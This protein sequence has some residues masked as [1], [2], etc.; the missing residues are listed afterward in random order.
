MSLPF[1]PPPRCIRSVRYSALLALFLCASSHAQLV[2]TVDVHG[3]NDPAGDGQSDITQLCIDESGLPDTFEVEFSWDDDSF[4]GRNTGDACV[5]FD[6]DGDAAGNIDYALCASV[7]GIPGRLVAG[8]TFYSCSGQPDQCAG[9]DLIGGGGGTT[10]LG[11]VRDTD[12]FGSGNDFP[13]D[14]VVNCVVD[15]A[16][17]P[18]GWART[19]FCSFPSSQPN[20]DPKDCIGYFG[21]GFIEISKRAFP[22]DDDSAATSFSFSVS[23][24]GTEDGSAVEVDETIIVNGNSSNAISVPQGGPYTVSEASQAGWTTTEASCDGGNV[25]GSTV[26]GITVAASSTTQC[27]F[28]NLRAGSITILKA[29]SPADGTDFAFSGDLESFALD[30]DADPTLSDSISFDSPVPGTYT[31]TEALTPPFALDS[32]LCEGD[33]DGGSVV[34]L[35]QRQVAIDFDAAEGI[36]CTFTNFTGADI[37]LTKT[38]DTAEPYTVGQSIQYT[39]VVSN[40]GP[41][42]AT[43]VLVSDT[44]TNLTIDS[45]S[46]VPLGTC[47][48][49]PCT[50]AS[51]A[52]GASE[53]ITVTAT[54]DAVG[55]FDNT[56]T[57][58]ADEADPDPGNNTD[59][60]DNGG[61]A[62]AAADPVL[63]VAKTTGAT[64]DNG[65]G[66]FTT[67]VTITLENLGNVVL[68]DVQAIDDLTA[69]FPAPAN[70][71]ISALTSATLAVNGSYDGSIAP[72]LLDGTDA[73]A[74]G[75]Q[76]TVNFDLTF[77]PMGLPGPF[78]NSASGTAQSDDGEVTT[79]LS[80]NGTDPD[81]NGNGDPGDPGEDDATPIAF[82]EAP[83]LGVAKAASPITDNGDGTFTTTVTVT[84]ENLGN[85]VLREVQVSDD[86]SL[87]FPLP[88][89]FSVAN[90]TSPL[91]SANTFFDGVSDTDLLLGTDVLAVG[92]RTTVAFDVTFDP[93]VL[94][95]PF[96]NS[97]SGQAVG[98]GGSPT[99]DVS[100]E[101]N[102]PDASGDGDPGGP[103]EDDPT[104]ITFIENPVLGVAKA[105]SPTTDNGDGTFTTTI[106]LLVEN[107]GNVILQGVQISDDLS[108]AFPAPATVVV[109]SPT[110]PTLATDAAFDGLG[111]QDLLLGTDSLGVGQTATVSFQLTFDPAGLSGPFSNTA[112][113]NAQSPIGASTSD[114]SDDGSDSDPDADGDP[115]GPGEDD[116][117]AITFIE[118]PVLGVAK[119]ASPTTDNGD[120]SFTTTITLTLENLGNVSL[121]DLQASDDLGAVFPAPASVSIANLTSPLLNLNPAYDGVSDIDLL[122]GSDS[123]PV[124]STATVSFDITFNPN[125]LA[126][127]FSNMAL[128]SA[129]GPAGTP[130]SDRSDNG[131]ETDSSGDGDPGGPGEDDP[132]TITFVENPVVDIAK[133]S[134]PASDN[135]DGTFTTT[136]TLLVENLGNVVLNDL[137][138]TDDL[139]ATF[140]SSVSFSVANLNSVS[141]TTNSVFD[142]VSDI[143]LLTGTD[144]LPVGGS[145][146]LAFDITFDPGAL[147]GPFLNTAI[148]SAAGPGGTGTSDRSNSGNDPDPNDNGDP[149]D[150]DEDV[151]TPISYVERPVLGVAK[152]AGPAVDN[153]NGTFTSTITVTLANLGN[154]LLST[155]QA[156]DDLSLSFPAPAT[157]SVSNPTSATLAANAAF[158]GAAVTTLLAG[159]DTL[160]VGQAASVTFDLT[161]DPNG[162]PGPFFNSARASGSGPGGTVSNDLSDAGSEPDAN[163]NGDPGEPGENDPTVIDFTEN[164]LLGLAKAVGATLDNGNGTFTTTVTIAVENLGN[165][166]LSSVQAVDDLSATFPAPAAFTVDNVFSAELT[167]NPLFDGVGD[168]DLL[169]GTDTLAV[170][171]S[172]QLSFDIT[173]D[174]QTLPGPFLNSAT[175][176]AQSPGG[177]VSSDR[178]DNGTQTDANGNGN[179]GDPDENDPSPI[180]FAE[181]PAIGLAKT[182]EPATDL[183]GGSFQTAVTLTVENLGNVV[184]SG[185]AISDDLAAIIPA[186][187][188]FSVSA[189]DSMTL[190]VN[191]AFD[192][193]ADTQLLSG[194]DSLAVGETASVSFVLTFQPNGVA[195]PF[196]NTA[197][198]QATGP[199]G[200]TSSDRSD[201]GTNTDS[202]GDGNPGGFGEDT[203]TPI[204]FDAQPV[205]G[206]AKDATPSIDNGDGTFT[207]TVTMVI[208]N[209][210]NVL[211]SNVQI[212]DDLQA[213]FPAPATFMTGAPVSARMSANPGFDGADSINLLSG[214]DTLAIGETASVSF[215]L[216]FAPNGAVG[217]FSNTAIASATDAGGQPTSDRSAAGSDPDPNGDGN[218]NLPGVEDSPTQIGFTERAVLG[219]AK[220]AEPVVDNL[221]G[222]FSV[223][224]T[225]YLENLG[226]VVLNNVQVS[227]DLRAV[228][229]EPSAFEI[230][231]LASLDLS[232]NPGF[233]GDADINM[234]LGTD[235]LDPGMTAEVS[236]NLLVWPT[237][238]SGTLNNFATA[239]AS[240][241]SGTPVTDTS[242]DGSDPD[243]DGNGSPSE[244]DP[245]PLQIIVEEISIPTLSELGLIVLILLLSGIGLWRLRV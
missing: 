236:F 64:S 183:G 168:T 178:S 133:S 50:L 203:P 45:V 197:I 6:L 102:T 69:A 161:F 206:A 47:N 121:N 54:I 142:G 130:T 184:L 115:G 232:V 25:S 97:A 73:L 245:T 60:S 88:A 12:P 36:L 85:V 70:F 71:S 5:L 118:N 76:A 146:T 165:V 49:L 239:D 208:E 189:I 59:G 42:A 26:T 175:A 106:T 177:D 145:A 163:G 92:Q 94:S 242:T 170:G 123:L 179:P 28:S 89:S 171:E 218:P 29:A 219:V 77:D 154:V 67:T 96:V 4:S 137:A 116:P 198:A 207:T 32:I 101:G 22:D 216:T 138:I 224:L 93:D 215:E 176:A 160:A 235:S 190:T 205:I 104:F 139:T 43:A 46:S 223:K 33:D 243:P 10:C 95:G 34:D 244:M 38:L 188:T 31:V 112:V 140:P 21:G 185:V 126:G 169:A 231:E 225:M 14:T 113:A 217:P 37:A 15:T 82:T 132:T 99:S 128:G 9:P 8:P 79:D 210:G 124:A 90:V 63:G 234:L 148:A 186:P 53:T 108:A 18:A 27:E 107:L 56:A 120:G 141:L 147:P 62:E 153:G 152:A 167:V 229:P 20:S 24:T 19:N 157:F 220:Q 81:A 52:D 103:G 111:N 194:T 78:L 65:D 221:D 241:S 72:D 61:T 44:P 191:P 80:D 23:G 2:C 35:G 17:I 40:G 158:D 213:T 110:S 200:G 105:A 86:L 48:A 117:T 122:L 13:A 155:V 211:L 129:I 1:S 136:I 181:N 57:A 204:S 100:D 119:A 228:F 174:P 164:P 230:S 201:N 156:V 214:T 238:Q 87:V 7:G 30:V 74:I 187:A 173:F 127:P 58:S 195:G 151:P 98:P 233:D 240:T 226:N 91:L 193:R 134:S 66:T 196:D 202:N 75:A 114:R 149:G 222:T 227:D 209:L 84:L 135:L 131:T 192:G 39:L 144:V 55:A 125:G 159:T 212:S 109:T 166:V 11:A 237:N 41:S 3:P 182:A 68:R 172:A 16:D 51:L 143:E 162:L 150:P 83:V 199:G 180:S